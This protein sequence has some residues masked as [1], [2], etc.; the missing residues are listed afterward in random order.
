MT[1]IDR[2]TNPPIE[3]YTKMNKTQLEKIE[4][5]NISKEL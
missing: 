5:Y 3:I 2:K 1:K 4:I